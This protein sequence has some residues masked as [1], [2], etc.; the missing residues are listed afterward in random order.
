MFLAPSL[1]LIC[2]YDNCCSMFQLYCT[3]ANCC[4]T[5]TFPV[6]SLL[7][8]SAPFLPLH[9]AFVFPFP[10]PVMARARACA[11]LNTMNDHCQVSLVL[12]CWAD[13]QNAQNSVMNACRS[14]ANMKYAGAFA[15]LELLRSR[16]K[17]ELASVMSPGCC[18]QQ[19]LLSASVHS[20][21]ASTMS[22]SEMATEVVKALMAC[23]LAVA[24]QPSRWH[25]VCCLTSHHFVL[26]QHPTFCEV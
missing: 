7:P 2:L 4:M 9:H 13:L 15:Q 22:M 1:I 23:E 26:V 18:A 12:L 5:V 14:I 17:D 19:A 8:A 21:L 20:G 11:R 16:Q 6:V 24:L 3:F 25:Q 10:L